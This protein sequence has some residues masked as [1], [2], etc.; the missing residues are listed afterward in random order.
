[1]TNSP[2]EIEGPLGLRGGRGRLEEEEEEDARTSE[3]SL[4][5]MR[6]STQRG[7]YNYNIIFTTVLLTP[8]FRTL[9]YYRPTYSTADGR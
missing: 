2:A 7:G 9:I 8:S 5:F 1:M 4:P 3:Q 6:T